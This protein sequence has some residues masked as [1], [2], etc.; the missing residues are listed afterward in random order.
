MSGVHPLEELL[1]S[2][3]LPHIWC[4]GCGIGIALNCFLRAVKELDINPDSI[5]FISGIGCTGRAAGYVNF[6]SFHTT[7]GRAIPLA[8]GVKVARPDM[9]VVVFSGDGDLFAIGGNHFIHAARRNVGLLVICI[10]NFNYGM[11]GGQLGPTTPFK[12]RTTTTPYGNIEHPFNLV[13]LAAAAGATYVARWTIAHPIPLTKSIEK[14]L[15]KRGFAFIEVVAPCITQYARYNKL[16]GPVE[17]MKYLK[18]SSVIKNF[19]DPAKAE[20]EVGGKIIV[21]EFV[22]TER[23]EYISE[24][25]RLIRERSGKDIKCLV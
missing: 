14:G 10:N 12:S 4:P 13:Y 18:K 5:A 2:D 7:H 8:M 24:L 9:H 25:Y 17:V 23:P 21:G 15:L 20:I 3:R 1:R 19:I 6:D 11:T 16:G 22:D